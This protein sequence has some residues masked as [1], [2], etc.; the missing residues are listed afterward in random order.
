ML[1]YNV[2]FLLFFV[3]NWNANFLNKVFIVRIIIYA[4]FNVHTTASSIA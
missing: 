3:G 2:F 1:Y 4:T